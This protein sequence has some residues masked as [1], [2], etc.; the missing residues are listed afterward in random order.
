[1][2]EEIVEVGDRNP[3]QRTAEQV[4]HVLVLQIVR[5]ILEIAETPQERVQRSTIEQ[6]ADAPAPC[7]DIVQVADGLVPRV[8][9]EIVDAAK[10][11]PQLIAV[12]G[13]HCLAL[14]AK[15]QKRVRRAVATNDWLPLLDYLD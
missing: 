13:D 6:T 11:F 1:V 4:T 8:G 3:Q 10:A 9:E 12:L 5:E 2:V 7:A 14:S 15:V